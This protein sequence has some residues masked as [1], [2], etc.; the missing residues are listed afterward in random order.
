M[1]EQQKTTPEEQSAPF[2][3]SCFGDMAK[4]QE[5]MAAQ[6]MRGCDCSGMMAQMMAMLGKAESDTANT[7]APNDADITV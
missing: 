5:K 3:V 1:S 4:M 6:A 7:E 2:G